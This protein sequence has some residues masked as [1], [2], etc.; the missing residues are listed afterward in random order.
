MN[1]SSEPRVTASFGDHPFQFLDVIQE[2]HY[3][4]NNQKG[5]FIMNFAFMQTLETVWFI[6]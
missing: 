1:G 2:S 3:V 5:I 4:L 6:K